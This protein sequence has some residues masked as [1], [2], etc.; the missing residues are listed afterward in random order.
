[1]KPYLMRFSLLLSALV[2]APCVL[3]QPDVI[4]RL[5][6]QGV[7][8]ATGTPEALQQVMAAEVKRWSA[9]IKNA[10]IIVD[11]PR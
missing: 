3:A 9:V 10:G 2:F 8:V 4:Q 5:L 6:D 7:E 11:A 1:M